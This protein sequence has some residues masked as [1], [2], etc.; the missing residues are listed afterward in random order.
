MTENE[1]AITKTTMN[2]KKAQCSRSNFTNKLCEHYVKHRVF[3]G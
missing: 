3:C 1:I 2:T